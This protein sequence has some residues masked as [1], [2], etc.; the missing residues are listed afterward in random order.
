MTELDNRISNY[1]AINT[2][3]E[4][5][6]DLIGRPSKLLVWFSVLLICMIFMGAVL[7]SLYIKCPQSITTNI[8]ILSSV[9]TMEIIPET[10]G[11]VENILVNDGEK[12]KQEDTIVILHDGIQCYHIKSPI[13]GTMGYIGPLSK[14]QHVGRGTL[15]GYVI[16]NE[17]GDFWGWGLIS[18]SNLY[19]IH[20][21]DRCVINLDRYPSEDYGNLEGCIA[22][23]GAIPVMEDKHFVKIAFPNGIITNMGKTIECQNKL[24]GT[25][26]IIVQDRK[27]LDIIL[28]PVGRFLENI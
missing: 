10:A 9:S 16:P 11:W 25:V 1:N 23:I 26:S 27:V 19:N 3:K 17:V 20:I 5:I 24:Q 15:L 18:E 13:D 14:Y 12:V 28:Q 2:D 8:E 21:G 7:G 6:S 22:S 4:E